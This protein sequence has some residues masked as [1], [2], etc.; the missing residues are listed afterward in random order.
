[1]SPK[2]RARA[3]PRRRAR[4]RAAR[5]RLTRTSARP[6]RDRDVDTSAWEGTDARV[7]REPPAHMV[8]E[9]VLELLVLLAASWDEGVQQEAS[10]ALASF[11][12]RPRHRTAVIRAGAFEKL[13]EQLKSP[14][15][16]VRYHGALALMA[17][18]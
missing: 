17:I 6:H 4:P 7:R 13:L 11:A 1:M 15:A 9:G 12:E 2:R 16:A 10:I 14:S 18:Q 3:P 8:D 5:L